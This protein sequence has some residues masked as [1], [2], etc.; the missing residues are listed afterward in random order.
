MKTQI[1]F[2][3]LIPPKEIKEEVTQFKLYAS[4]HFNASHAL[5]SPPHI[6][7]FPPFVWPKEKESFL[8]DALENFGQLHSAVPVELRHF[9]SFGQR[10][11][12]VDVLFTEELND[13]RNSLV[14]YLKQQIDL[15]HSD[16]RPFHPHMTL[17]FK[18]LKPAFF[19]K[20]WNYFSQLT[21]ERNFVADELFLLRHDGVKWQIIQNVGLTLK[22]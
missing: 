16:S 15:N 6:T 22:P 18:D 7:L 11:I 17:A 5:K 10:V 19:S 1:F 20:A 4:R 21:F 2:I 3:A 13:L 14:L 9:N 12:F 8:K